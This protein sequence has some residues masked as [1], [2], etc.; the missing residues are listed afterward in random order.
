MFLVL[1]VKPNIVNKSNFKQKFKQNKSFRFEKNCQIQFVKKMG[2]KT[3]WSIISGS[4]ELIDLREL[5]GSTVAIDLA[6]EKLIS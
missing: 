2:V 6:G 4:G 5:Q 3:L 1:F